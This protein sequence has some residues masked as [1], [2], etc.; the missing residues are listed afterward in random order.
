MMAS[1][2]SVGRVFRFGRFEAN[3]ARNTLLGDG[4]RVRI[5]D[6]PF[7]VL[8]L[9]LERPG[10]IVTRDELRQQLW[11]EGIHVDF[12]GSLN[13]ILKKL[14]TAL[15][16]DAEHP[17]FIETAPR[18]GYRFIAPVTIEEFPFPVRTV[19]TAPAPPT[20]EPTRPVAIAASR[21]LTRGM[22]PQLPSSLLRSLQQDGSPG[23]RGTSSPIRS[24][25]LLVRTRICRCEGRW[26]SWG[27]TMLLAEA[28]MRGSPQ[29]FQ[30]C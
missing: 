15:G 5:H 30:K 16:D 14:R 24:T 4:I 3:V 23:A 21:F 29:H 20:V 11:P 9:L 2:T 26:Q 25:F 12:D 6:Q 7:R 22:R 18:Q 27:S 10:E 28:T 13:A 1:T 19:A 17:R 8:I